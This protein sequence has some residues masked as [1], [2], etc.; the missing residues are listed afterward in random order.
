MKT[1]LVTVLLST[2]LSLFT[3]A[4]IPD[5]LPFYDF[6]TPYKVITLPAALQEIS[7]VT[8]ID[9]DTIACVQD[10][11]GFIYVYDLKAQKVR[12]EIKFHGK[13][14][15]EGIALA[16]PDMYV[17]ESSGTLYRVSDYAL[18][19]PETQKIDTGITTIDNEGLCFQPG[20][21][22]LYISSKTELEKK[23]KKRHYVYRYDIK[24]WKMEKKPFLSIEA[25][26][27]EK[28]AKKKEIKIP[29]GGLKFVPSD[30]AVHP[31]TEYVYVL[32]SVEHLIY[33]FSRKGN[34]RDIHPLDKRI[35]NQPEGLCFLPDNT[36]VITNEGGKSLPS[37]IMIKSRPSP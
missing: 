37:L 16:G 19:N 22:E 1:I 2:F 34:L 20:K 14:D 23:S 29:K 24:K 11:K 36:L 18:G 7:G 26:K 15:Y 32:S 25:E 30:I 12:E 10:E 6:N 28:D 13:G 27:L 17:L 35:F 21:H 33:V 31:A 4:E 3:A 5:N 8:A 9:A